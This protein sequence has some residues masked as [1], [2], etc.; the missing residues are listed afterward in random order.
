MPS[1]AVNTCLYLV[2]GG[3]P[4]DG[5]LLLPNVSGAQCEH[6]TGAN[7]VAVLARRLIFPSSDLVLLSGFRGWFVFDA[8]TVDAFTRHNLFKRRGC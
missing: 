5:C 1:W 7:L 2:Y 6:T 4:E 8:F 3:M